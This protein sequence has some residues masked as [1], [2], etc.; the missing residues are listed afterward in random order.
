MKYRIIFILIVL[1]SVH[2][3]AQKSIYPKDITEHC[4]ISKKNNGTNR[5]ECSKL[6]IDLNGPR[7]EYAILIMTLAME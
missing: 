5:I 1:S 6:S 2:L 4:S 3:N 7:G